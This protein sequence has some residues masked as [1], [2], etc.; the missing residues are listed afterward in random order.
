VGGWVSGM[1][2]W[3]EGRWMGEWVK[4]EWMCDWDAFMGG[5]CVDV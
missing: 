4:G 2:T 1:H 5:G 3:V